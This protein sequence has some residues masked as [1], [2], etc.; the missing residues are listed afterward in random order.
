MTKS[1]LLRRIEEYAHLKGLVLGQELGSGI[2]GIVLDA[3]N[4]LNGDHSAVKVYRRDTFYIPER[5][6]YFRLRD[7]GITTVCGHNVPQLINYDD[8]L[9]VIEMTIVE[10]PFVLDFAGAYLDKPPDFS[11]EVIADWQAE[12]LEQ[13]GEKWTDVQ[14]VLGSLEAFGIYMVDVNPG[15]VAF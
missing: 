10:R 11:D 14:T 2:H 4:Q 15:N 7:L 5:D 9:L 12:K 6:V 8:R 13:F 3:K 1:D